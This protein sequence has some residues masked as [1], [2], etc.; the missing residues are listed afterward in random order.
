MQINSILLIE[1]QLK[2]IHNHW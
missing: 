2:P 1:L